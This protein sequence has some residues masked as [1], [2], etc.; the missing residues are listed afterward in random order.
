MTTRSPVSSRMPARAVGAEDPRLGHRREAFADPEV[1]V[2]QRRGAQTDEHLSGPARDRARPRSGEPPDRRPRGSELPSPGTIFHTAGAEP[3]GGGA[4]PR[5]RRG[6]SRVR[7]RETERHI[8]ERRERGL[9][10]DMRFTMARPEQSCHPELLLEGARTVVS[11]ALCY[12]GRSAEPPPPARAGCPATPGGRLRGA[13][14]AARRARPAA[15]RRLPRA[16]GR[17]PAR[18]P[19]GGGA[20]RRRLLRQEHAADHAP[21]RLLGRAG[22]ARHRREL[23]ST[24]PLG[25]DC[26]SC[27]PLHRGLPDRRARRARRRSTRR[28]ASPT[29]R[30]PPTPIPEPYRERLDDQVYGCDICQDVCPWNRGVERR[31]AG[32]APPAGAEPHVSLVDWLEADGRGAGAA[33]RPALR[34]AQRPALPA[35]QRPRRARQHRR[36]ADATPLASVRATGTTRSCASTPSGRSARLRR[37]A[38]ERRAERRRTSSAGSR[39][40][41][42]ACRAVRDPPGR[43]A[44]RLPA[45]LRVWAW[46]TTASS[47][48][49]RWRSSGSAGAT[50]TRHRAAPCSGSSRSPSTSRSSPPTSWSSASSTPRPMRQLILRRSSRPR[51]ASASAAAVIARRGAAPGPGRLRVAARATTSDRPRFQLDCVTL[52]LGVELLMGLIVGWLVGRLDE[53]GR[54]AAGAGRRGRAPARPARAARRHAR[55]RQP[56]RAGAQLVARARAGLRRL[57][58]RAARPLPFDRIAIVLARGRHGPG[59]GGRRRRRGR[60]LPARLRA[61]ARRHRSWRSVLAGQTVYRR[62]MTSAEYPEEGEFLALGLRCRLAA[63]LLRRVRARS[64]CSR[65]SARR[66]GRVH[67]RGDRAGRAARPP[68]RERRA[69]HP[70]VRGRAADRRRAAAPL[71]AAR[72]LRLARLAR[73]AHPDGGGDRLGADAAAALARAR[74][75][76]SASR[77]SR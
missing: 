29:G 21:V 58:P 34:A 47:R 4:R 9:F 66:A 64:G 72:G 76:S 22:H 11:A 10:A 43:V 13:A 42:L 2:I 70:R 60:R 69:E 52:Q 40:I 57:H 51:C 26:G 39:W 48:S 50:G 37:S 16:R 25:A 23:E 3:P 77:S 61:A 1:E 71:G 46:V 68:R 38:R 75:R 32:E 55:R 73:A 14:R 24:P 8:R 59:D 67:A 18:R 20:L 12:S 15:R 7:L 53:R 17:E 56:L 5:R 44:Q 54:V 45:R 30:R 33:L 35:P 41:R 49:A 63:P 28:A 31:R 36:R 62:D 65:S 74:R 27:T 19:R 6:G